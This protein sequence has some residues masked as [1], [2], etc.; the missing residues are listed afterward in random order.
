MTD[1]KNILMVAAEKQ[2]EALRMASGLTLLDDAVRIVAWGKLPDEP[3]VAEQMEALAFAEV[4][5]DE[6]EASSSGMGVLA[7]Q[8]IDN[9][10]VFIV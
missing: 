5:L 10:V 9:D 2:A 1:R 6:L 4:P 7:R 8:I 3:A